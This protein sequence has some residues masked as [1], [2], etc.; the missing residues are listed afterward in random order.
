MGVGQIWVV[1]L[2]GFLASGAAAML[3]ADEP[4]AIFVMKVDGSDVRRVGEVA[5]H[6]QLG[7][8]RWSR[9]GKRLAFHTAGADANARRWFVADA[10]G[11]GLRPFGLGAYP[12]WSPEDKQLVFGIAEKTPV[13]PGIWVQNDDGRGRL[14]LWK[15]GAAPRWSPAGDKLAFVDD[16]T[17]AVLD[18]VESGRQQLDLPPGVLAGFDWS[19]DGTQLAFVT[20]GD[21]TND[22]WIADVEDNAN[23]TKLLSGDVDG[24]VAWSP[25]GERLAITQGDQIHLLAVDGR[26]ARADP[27]SAG[28]ES[29][30]GL[31]A[32]RSV[33]RLCQHAR[34]AETGARGRRGASCGSRRSSVTTGAAPCTASL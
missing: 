16:G 22:L 5:Q 23:R 24:Y 14:L 3:H 27:Q 21:K 26:G 18:L 29:H 1:A 34:Y 12:D 11:G 25:D 8:L 6:P 20:E 30:A 15:G 10:D 2:V 19:P 31:V 4:S 17:L 13:A 32:R 7:A 28:R 9:D 33:D